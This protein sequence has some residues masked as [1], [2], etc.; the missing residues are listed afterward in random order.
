[1]PKGIKK[2]ETF[3]IPVSVITE[4]EEY[5]FA[6]SRLTKGILEVVKLKHNWP[7]YP[8]EEDIPEDAVIL[9]VKILD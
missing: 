8:E 5:R 7:S 4:L 2:K 9:E 6:G 1:M 3:I